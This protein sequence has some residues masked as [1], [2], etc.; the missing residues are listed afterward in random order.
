VSA[1]QSRRRH[2]GPIPKRDRE[3]FLQVLRGGWSATKAAEATPIE[4]RRFHALRKADEAFDRAWTEASETGLDRLRDEAYR[5]AFEGVRD[6]RLDKDGVEHELIVYSDKLIELLLKY[7]DH[8]YRERSQVEITGAGGK[9]FEVGVRVEHDYAEILE[10]LEQAGLIVRG[11]AA[12]TGDA[13]PLALLP[14]RTDGQADDGPRSPSL[15][16][17]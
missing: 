14:A 16:A 15:P 9:P 12:R 8:G 2:D 6:F 4:R 10:G 7:H 5:R 3:T 13:A 11:P 1:V 17:D